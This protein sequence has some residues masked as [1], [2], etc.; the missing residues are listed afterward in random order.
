[1]LISFSELLKGFQLNFLSPVY[2]NF[3][4]L[5]MLSLLYLELISDMISFIERMRLMV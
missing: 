4:V 2:I 1:M 3:T 5:Y